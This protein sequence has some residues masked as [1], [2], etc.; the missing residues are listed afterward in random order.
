MSRPESQAAPRSLPCLQTP[1]AQ[2]EQP[3]TPANLVRRPKEPRPFL[4]ALLRA[5]GAWPT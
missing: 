1:V 4:R 3:R 5:L 2:I